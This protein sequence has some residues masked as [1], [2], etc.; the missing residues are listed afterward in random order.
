MMDVYISGPPEDVRLLAECNGWQ[1]RFRFRDAPVT[2]AVRL[3]VA[4]V[5]ARRPFSVSRGDGI[6]ISTHESDGICRYAGIG[7]DF[8][9][10]VCSLL[11][12][13]QW[14]ALVL[15]ELLI[16]EDFFVH[17]EPPGCL[18]AARDTIQE[19]ALAFECPHV[20]DAC[21]EFFRCLGA[22][23]EVMALQEVLNGAMLPRRL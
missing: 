13:V 3:A 23:P 6:L 8:Y 17:E 7:K 22:E 10:A 15:N 14:R 4:D 5:E 9:L 21:L 20:C 16:W 11:G 18:Y 2:G 1:K 19:Y 12:L